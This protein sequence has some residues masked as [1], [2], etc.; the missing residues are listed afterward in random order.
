VLRGT[1][2]DKWHPRY[3]WHAGFPLGHLAVMEATE[4]KET[5]AARAGLGPRDHPVQKEKK[6]IKESLGR[7]APPVKRDSEE[8]KVELK[9]R[10]SFPR[11]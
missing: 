3:A 8:R 7:G 4:P 5:R 6:E 2:R 9:D 10:L 11:T 1:T